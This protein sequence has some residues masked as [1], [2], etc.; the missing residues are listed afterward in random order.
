MAQIIPP[1]L[2]RNG[3]LLITAD[4]GNVEE[5]INLKTHGK[6]TEHSSNPVPLWYVTPTNHREKTEEEMIATVQGFL[7]DVAPT[8][9]EIMD[10]P[11][12]PEMTCTSLL[13]LLQ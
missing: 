4:H 10:I 11:K 12:P 6:D 7:C 8:V 9:L 3:C 1:V 2:E 13:P 5:L